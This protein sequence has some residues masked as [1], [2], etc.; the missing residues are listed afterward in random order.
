M[1][2]IDIVL[3]EFTGRKALF[4]SIDIAN[5]VKRRGTWV[6]NRDVALYMRQHELLAPGGDYLMT[7]TTCLLKDGRSAPAYVCHPAGTLV[8]EYRE[9]LQPA[10]SPQEFAVLHPSAPVPTPPPPSSNRQD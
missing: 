4:T 10:M 8:T 1:Q 7:L 5:E 2:E 3:R 9:I 6:P